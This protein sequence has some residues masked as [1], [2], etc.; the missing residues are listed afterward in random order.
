MLSWN[1][2]ALVTRPSMTSKQA[3]SRL[4]STRHRPRPRSRAGGAGRARRSSRRGTG[5]R[6]VAAGDDRAE[7]DAVLGGAEH[8][9]GVRRAPRST[10]SRSSSASASGRS[11]VTGWSRRSW[12]AFQPICGTRSV[13]GNRRTSPWSQPRQSA[14]PSSLCSNSTW[15][16]MQI[17]RNGTRSSSTRARSGSS[18][19]DSSSEASVA[20]A[21]PTPGRM[22]RSTSASA[23]GVGDESGVEPEAVERVH[24]ARGVAGPVVDDADHG[25]LRERSGTGRA[26]ESTDPYRSDS[27][28]WARADCGSERIERVDVDRAVLVHS[29]NGYG[30]S[31]TRQLAW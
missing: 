27:E 19:S 12:T 18:S 31:L 17:P 9:L 16:P 8:V 4:V 6:Y 28:D 5:S 3:M 21:A 29:W 20:R 11:A 22:I 7:L 23:V 1:C 25:E 14:G 24:H 2:C 26:V 13:S 10:S 15:R 30:V